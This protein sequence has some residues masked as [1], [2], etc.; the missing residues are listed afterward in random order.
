MRNSF[1]DLVKVLKFQ[2]TLKA[3]GFSPIGWYDGMLVWKKNAE[4]SVTRIL[5]DIDTTRIFPIDNL[6]AIYLG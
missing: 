5:T 6:N 3:E 4:G 1:K 2:D